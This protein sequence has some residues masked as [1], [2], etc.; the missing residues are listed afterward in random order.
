MTL[1]WWLRGLLAAEVALLAWLA[2]VLEARGWTWTAIAGVVVGAAVAWRA[3][4]ALTSFGVAALLRARDG[5]RDAPR[6]AWYAVMSECLARLISYNWSQPFPGLAMP[7]E[8]VGTQDGIPVV[9]V[10]GY[11]S[12]RGMWVRFRERLHAAQIAGIGPIHA[13][14]LGPPFWGI[15]A[16]AKTL[17]ARLDAIAASSGYTSCIVIAH[18]MGGLV[19]RRMMA[20]YGAARVAQLITLGTPHHGTRMAWFGLG[21]CVRE[22]RPNSAWLQQLAADESQRAA[23]VPCLSLYT[24]NDDLVYPPESAALPWATNVAVDGVGHVALLFDEGVF[25]QLRDILKDMK[26]KH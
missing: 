22:M 25:V 1:A 24:R 10:H 2:V 20:T 14:D 12:N 18:S 6:S 4:H 3:S 16:F 5:R 17:R 11:F 15:D 19:T 7:G 21:R 8:P 23:T 9:L 26:A 13:V